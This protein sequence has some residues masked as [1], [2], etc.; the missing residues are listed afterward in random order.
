MNVMACV[1]E[2]AVTGWASACHLQRWD[3]EVPPTHAAGHRGP[4]ASI[5]GPSGT[6]LLLT[7]PHLWAPQQLE[8][9]PKKI[10]KKNSGCRRGSEVGGKAVGGTEHGLGHRGP[11][12]SSY[13]T[14]SVPGKV[15]GLGRCDRD[16]EEV[17]AEG[18]WAGDPSA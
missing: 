2:D 13:N 12:G 3:P 4:P 10:A 14:Q 7:F 5:T 9:N 18:K 8:L 6:G 11:H 17:A 16:G 15:G 1:S